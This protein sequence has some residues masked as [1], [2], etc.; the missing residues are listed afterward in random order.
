MF[1]I[2]ERSTG[3][4][5]GMK[6][7]GKLVHEDYAQ[8]VPKL[9][10]LIE[11]HGSIRCYCE[12]TDFHGITPHALW[13]ELK[14]DV[15]HFKDVERCAMVGDPSWHQWMT[16]TGQ[17]IFSHAQMRYFDQSQ[18][19][20]AWQWVSEGVESNNRIEPEATTTSA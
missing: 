5:I 7:Q 4:V 6:V 14:F 3:N 13:D 18:S 9:E 1:E 15:K 20:E 17:A 16:K 8:F 2:L 11:E 12:L 10:K 19:E